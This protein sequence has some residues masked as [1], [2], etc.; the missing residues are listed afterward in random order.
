VREGDPVAESVTNTNAAGKGPIPPNLLS[1]LETERACLARNGAVQLRA[2]PDRQRS[3]RLRYR[4]LDVEAG[5]AKHRSIPLGSDR[6]LAEAVQGLLGYWRARHEAGREE[7]RRK[8][9][10]AAATAREANRLEQHLVKLLLGQDNAVLGGLSTGQPV[11]R[12]G[13]PPASGLC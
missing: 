10:V 4:A 5:Y 6:A 8:A 13:R 1:K 12:R 7:E 11:R 2:D 9:A 3:F